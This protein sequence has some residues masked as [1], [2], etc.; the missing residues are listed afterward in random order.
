MFIER[1]MKDREDVTDLAQ[2]V[3]LKVFE[4]WKEFETEENAKFL[5]ISCFF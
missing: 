1:V 4:R 3:F 5:Y 2:D